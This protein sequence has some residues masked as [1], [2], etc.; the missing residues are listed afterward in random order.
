MTELLNFIASLLTYVKFLASNA[1]M[2]PCLTHCVLPI[3]ISRSDISFG[4]LPT[5]SIFVSKF[6]PYHL[7]TV[8]GLLFSLLLFNS[9]L[10]STCLRLWVDLHSVPPG[11]TLFTMQ[12]H[13]IRPVPRY[14]VRQLPGVPDNKGKEGFLPSKIIP[15]LSSR[16]L[17]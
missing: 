14:F 16:P 5:F 17:C 2:T 8:Q 4:S 7:S 12:L 11:A 10:F 6:S 1:S 3:S 15:E 9:V 13:S